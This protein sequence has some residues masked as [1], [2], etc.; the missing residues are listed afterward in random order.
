[1]KGDEIVHSP[2]EGIVVLSV[3]GHQPGPYATLLLADLGADVIVVERPNGGDPSREFPALYD[4]LNRSKRSICLDLKCEEDQA[5]LR[6]LV[7]SADVFIE[8]YR[9]GTVDRLGIDYPTLSAIKPDLIYASIS[10]F[11]QDGPYRDRPAHDLSC[12]GLA[13]ALFRQARNGKAEEPSYIP[14]SD[15]SSGMFATLGIL[16]ALFARMQTGLGTYIDTSMTESVTSLMTSYLYAAMNGEKLE[17]VVEPEPAYGSF[18]CRGGKMITLSVSE[19]DWFWTNLCKAFELDDIA[20]LVHRERV[21]KVETLRLRLAETFARFS[22]EELGEIFDK[23]DI[24]WGPLY[25]LS[26]VASD[27]HLRARGLFA[28]ID[29]PSKQRRESFVSLPIKFSN[30]KT[31]TMSPAPLLG[32]HT[33]EILKATRRSRNSGR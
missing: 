2:L 13:G 33:E 12:Q 24:P 11:G 17:E 8:G 16:S 25:D 3:A 10:G 26:D 28:E 27:P 4:S 22:R 7:K 21:E 18:V 31:A 32:Q 19:E 20:D 1:M 5:N 9:P 29:N 23:W 6:E 15:L 30:Y 14:L